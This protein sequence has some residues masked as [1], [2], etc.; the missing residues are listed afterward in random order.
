M[1]GGGFAGTVQAFVH[2][3]LSDTYRK[4]LDT[5]FGEGAAMQLR[6][7]PVGAIRVDL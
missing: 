5:V 7:R 2:R 3:D 6:I 4:A 1:H